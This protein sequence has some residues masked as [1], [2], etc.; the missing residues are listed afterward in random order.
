[1]I[2]AW[3]QLRDGVRD[4]GVLGGMK[5]RT[6]AAALASAYQKARELRPAFDRSTREHLDKLS[7]LEEARCSSMDEAADAFAAWDVKV[8]F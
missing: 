7:A 4:H 6:A 5:Y 3:W 1:M 2:L 8:L